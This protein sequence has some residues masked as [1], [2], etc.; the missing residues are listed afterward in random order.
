[1]KKSTQIYGFIFGFFCIVF[2]EIN[3]QV[4]KTNFEISKKKYTLLYNIFIF[5]IHYITTDL[6]SYIR[7]LK[8]SSVL[9]MK[10]Y[11]LLAVLVATVSCGDLNQQVEDKLNLLNNKADKLDSIVNKELD[12][13]HTL[14]S[15]IEK[16]GSKVKRLDSLIDKSTS[17]LD[18]IANAKKT[19]V[20]KLTQ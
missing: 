1:M 2:I 4:Y 6:L 17:K 7:Y 5:N 18:S 11:I 13:V 3:L 12:K 14:D 19:A 10:N 16:E 9:P 15:L 8:L 20:E